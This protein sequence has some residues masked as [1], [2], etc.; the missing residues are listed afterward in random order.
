[1]NDGN[2]AKAIDH[3]QQGIRGYVPELIGREIAPL[4][5][6][7]EAYPILAGTSADLKYKV[8]FYGYDGAYLLRLFDESELSFK[9]FE[10]EALHRM[11]SMTVHCSRPIAMGRWET[12]NVYFLLVSYI[13]GIDA[14][15][16]L[17]TVP[18]P[19][20]LRIGMQAGEELSRISAY[21][22]P[23]GIEPWADRYRK[24]IKQ[25]LELV[26]KHAVSS[27]GVAAAIEMIEATQ[28][29]VE[30]RPSVFL[31]GNF[32][33]ANLIVHH[34]RLTGVVGF[35][36]FDWGDPLYEFAKLGLY[37]RELSSL[38]CTGQ[39]L[40]YHGGQAPCAEF[41]GLYRLY[42]ASAAISLLAE[43]VANQSPQ[44]NRV[45]KSIDR[46]AQDHHDFREEQP[47]WF[48]SL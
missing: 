2:R 44:L 47:S 38:F 5:K 18:K 23:E 26:T 37:S 30:E 41:W 13:D 9:R 32:R 31:H 11:Q 25:Q 12:K 33:P 48:A 17:S 35:G 6:I 15:Q 43:V 39:I 20:Q 4:G 34:S 1:M 7:I 42:A 19:Q 10:F 28:N 22:A 24:K 21:P 14:G 3:L 29:L 45:L 8:H 36:H 16:I 27:K 46:L 40:G